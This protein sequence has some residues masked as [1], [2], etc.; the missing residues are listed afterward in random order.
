MY[1][2]V[3]CCL[4]AVNMFMVDVGRYIDGSYELVSWLVF[5]LDCGFHHHFRNCF[6]LPCV[7]PS[8]SR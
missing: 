8:Q 5:V 7:Q 1:G 4:H 6:V 3:A 2:I